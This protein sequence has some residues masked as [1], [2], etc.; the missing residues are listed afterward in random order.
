MNIIVC[1]Q[2]Y[3]DTDIK[4]SL[5]GGDEDGIG[6]VALNHPGDGALCLAI[7]EGEHRGV[8]REKSDAVSWT[9]RE[10]EREGEK[11]GEKKRE[12]ERQSERGGRRGAA[13]DDMMIM[14]A[15]IMWW[16]V[17]KTVRESIYTHLCS[18]LTVSQSI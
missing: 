13:D 4:F 10:R 7:N 2:Q 9:D 17:M 3:P 11:D 12:R 6:D 1:I 16:V 18:H 15:A 5:S 8:V 14:I